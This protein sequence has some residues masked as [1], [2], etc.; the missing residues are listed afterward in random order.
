MVLKKLSQWEKWAQLLDERGKTLLVGG[1]ST[2][3][4]LVFHFESL[5]TMRLLSVPRIYEGENKTQMVNVFSMFYTG[6]DQWGW[7]VAQWSLL[8]MDEANPLHPAPN[9]NPPKNKP[10]ECPDRSLVNFKTH[11]TTDWPLWLEDF[12]T[13]EQASHNILAHALKLYQGLC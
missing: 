2:Q 9:W 3:L 1:I 13:S 8:S 11:Q 12:I 5:C 6:V 10:S 7:G 4:L